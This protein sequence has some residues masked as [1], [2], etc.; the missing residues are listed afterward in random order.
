MLTSSSPSARRHT[1]LTMQ[2][3]LRLTPA[4]VRCRQEEWLNETMERAELL[5]EELD[6]IF[7]AWMLSES[8]NSEFTFRHFVR[9]C[10]HCGLVSRRLG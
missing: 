9:L 10:E 6:H 3:R 5:R 1:R 4:E 8:A 7:D 2:A